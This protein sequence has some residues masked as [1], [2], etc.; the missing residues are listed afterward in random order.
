MYMGPITRAKPAVSPT[1]RR[2]VG[3]VAL[4]LA[5]LLLLPFLSAYAL[6]AGTVIGMRSLGGAPR[7]LG[8]AVDYAGGVLVGR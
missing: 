6:Y 7:L 5:G 3:A 1:V 4:P 2:A 8:Q